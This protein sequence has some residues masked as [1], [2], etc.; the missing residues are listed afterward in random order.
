MMPYD[1]PKSPTTFD[2]ANVAFQ[3]LWVSGHDGRDLAIAFV[4]VAKTVVQM[5]S[6]GKD[7]ETL[8]KIL[9]DK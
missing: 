5:E 7:I 3:Q 8:R 2:L 6:A 1:P 9:E 4:Q